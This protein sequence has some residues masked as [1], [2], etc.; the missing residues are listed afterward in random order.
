LKLASGQLY[1]WPDFV[2]DWAELA[3]C[4]GC[5]ILKQDDE[6]D[7]ENGEPC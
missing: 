1:G 3:A 2:I 7:D 6:S 4:G 5:I